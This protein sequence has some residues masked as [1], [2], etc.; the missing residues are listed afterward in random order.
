MRLS[1]GAPPGAGPAG[2]L[3]WG[4]LLIAWLSPGT[5]GGQV[6]LTQD[7]AL[8]VAFPPPAT[9]ERRTAY[10]S[11]QELERARTLAGADVNVEAAI[12]TYYVGRDGSRSVGV[13]YFDAHRVR[14]LQEVLMIVVTP[15]AQVKSIEVLRFSEPRDYLAP[16]GWLEQFERRGL[17]EELS[18][19]RGIVNITGATLTSSAVT[20]AVR[21]TLAL[22]DVV[23]PFEAGEAP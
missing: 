19:R 7:E 20:R 18:V 15:E 10:L 11:E 1:R 6:F 2:R 21:R 3:G 17:D 23:A 9:V 13:A 14:T 4:T 22:H 8:A 16:G 12:V 5:A